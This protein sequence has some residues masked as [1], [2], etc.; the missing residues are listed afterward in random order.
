MNPLLISRD[1]ALSEIVESVAAAA[2]VHLDLARDVDRI[3]AAWRG[4]PVVL[5]GSDLA[6]TVLGMALPH[7][8][9]VHLCTTDADSALAWSMPLG[10]PVLVLPQHTGFLSAVISGDQDA[11]RSAVVVRVIGGSGGVGATTFA[12][13]LAL[14]G[15]H[16]SMSAALVELDEWGGGIDL[17]MGAEKTPGWRWPDLTAASGH[18]GDI[19]AHLPTVLGVDLLAMRA[20]SNTT[21]SNAAIN[22]VLASLRRSHQLVILDS[23]ARWE[24]TSHVDHDVLL[25]ASGVKQVLATRS[26][27]E[28]LGL[29]DAHLVVRR[30]PGASLSPELVGEALGLEVNG[31]VGD[32]RR[33][34][35][36]AASGVPPRA[37]RRVNKVCDR[38]L[39][40]MAVSDDQA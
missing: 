1:R 34:A 25:V 13:A 30:R 22:S 36:D 4:A 16:R 37:S 10:A 27:M 38:L 3:R 32:D 18:L 2:Q 7:R 40:A 33:L 9:G 24:A 15:A 6:A 29:S 23:G 17:V 35:T 31:V 20:T 19:T 5:I 12:A 21:P 39:D 11:G 14:R 26:R 8:P 28:I